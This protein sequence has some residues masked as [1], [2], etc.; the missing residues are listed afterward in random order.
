MSSGR[1]V[2]LR[3]VLVA[4]GDG[5]IHRES[6]EVRKGL[7]LRVGVSLR[8]KKERRYIAH[9]QATHGKVKE[10]MGKMQKRTAFHRE[11]CVW[12]SLS[13]FFYHP[14]SE[15][16]SKRSSMGIIWQTSQR[17]KPSL[18]QVFGSSFYALHNHCKWN[19]PSPSPF[20]FKWSHLV[21]QTAGVRGD[22]CL[23]TLEVAGPCPP[24]LPLQ[25]SG[26]TFGL[27][28]CSCVCW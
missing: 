16:L 19:R 24:C 21:F 12:D 18:Q 7:S 4:P 17:L 2:F 23:S 3:T 14:L 15:S 22:A 5:R 10:K 1:S 20:R 27:W 28:K 26:F 9:D 25:Q 6:Y 13:A 11:Q 8:E